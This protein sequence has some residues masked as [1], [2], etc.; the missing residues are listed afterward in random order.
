MS[1]TSTESTVL[2]ERHDRV[3]VLTINRP[4]KYNA[5]NAQVQR[6]LFAALDEVRDDDGIGV[7]VITG[8]GDKSFV[9]GADITEFE[10]RTPL[11]QREAMRFPRMFDILADYPKPAIAMVNGLCLGGGCELAL[12]CDLRIASEKAQFGLPEIKLGLIPGGGGTQRLPR[13][14]GLGQAMRMIL[15]GDFI[16]A[17]EARS[18]GLVEMVAA[19]D[20]LREKTLELAAHIATRSPATLRLAKEAV[21]ASQRLPLDQGIVY[22]RDLFCLAF[23]TE[24]KEEGVDAFINKRD[25]QWKGR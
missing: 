14:V 24:D 8:A 20:E 16:P 5:L 12:S 9:A 4:S 21:R 19:P 3:A 10:G 13:F 1:D 15:T 2:L 23:A 11:D 18:M 17:N 6:D 22:E 7:V 25:P